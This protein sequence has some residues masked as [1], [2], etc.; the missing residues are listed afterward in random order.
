MFKTHQHDFRTNFLFNEPLKLGVCN[1]T[2][3]R[4]INSSNQ[5]TK[6]LHQNLCFKILPES[7]YLVFQI[8][9]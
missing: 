5:N 6:K 3:D 1:N 4:Y 9:P 2:E 8:D 7:F